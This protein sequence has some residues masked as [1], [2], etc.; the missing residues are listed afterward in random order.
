MLANVIMNCLIRGPVL[1]LAALVLLPSCGEENA[2]RR[3]AYVLE[4]KQFVALLVDLALAESATGINIKSAMG[5][6]ID[7]TYNFDPLREHG[8]SQAQYDSTI[9][10][11]SSRPDAY[12]GVYDL[13]LVQLSALE[14]A[15]RA[16]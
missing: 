14:A 1:F 9:R 5:H 3:P 2:E 15:S 12:K 6:Q 11:Y 8:V 7:S 13:V 10:Y 16:V 4:E